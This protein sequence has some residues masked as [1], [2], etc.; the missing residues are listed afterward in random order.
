MVAAT[1][2]RIL[3]RIRTLA[4]H[5]HTGAT[6]G[7]L[8]DR[9]TQQQ[10][11]AAFEA[12]VRRHGPMVLGVCRR[13]LG[14]SHDAEDAFQATFLV[15]VRK[16]NSIR[17]VGMVGNWLYG[18]AQHTALEARR[19]AARRR[20]KEAQVTPRTQTPD[21]ACAH[22]R[23]ILDREL[24]RLPAKYRA[25]LVLCDLEGR[26]RKEAAQQL[27]LPEGT[28]AS[29][30]ARARTILAKRLTRQGVTISSGALATVLAQEAMSASPP[31]T[32]ILATVKVA[33]AYAAG[34][35]AM[36][37]SVVV[38]T[39]GVLKAMF[40]SKL[41]I[42]VIVVAVVGFLSAGWGIGPMLRTAAAGPQERAT[43]ATPAA[44]PP[45]KT[46]PNQKQ[47]VDRDEVRQAFDEMLQMLQTYQGS[48]VSANRN[49]QATR[50]VSA[51][52]FLTAFWISSE[53]AKAL[54]KGR[55]KA[56]PVNDAALDAYGLFVPA[57][58]RAGSL[59]KTLEQQQASGVKGN[60]KAI[61]ALDVFLKA[62]QKFELAIKR[63]VKT[64]AVDQA[65]QAIKDAVS[66]VEQTVQDRQTTLETLDEIERALQDLKTKVQTSKEGK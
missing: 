41:K 37:A 46:N 12:L 32:L 28:V 51:E 57:Y 3:Y 62:G 50:D 10:D 66:K 49:E 29:R 61:E 27:G 59:K 34:A 52:A 56:A 15:L 8:L 47:P 1:A 21:D 24:A 17:P 55:G 4:L 7:D 64:R 42:G 18:V 40:L 33:T 26:T 6:D 63:Q 44:D 19:S 48:K 43:T 16:A 58:E 11:E 9:Y 20:A 23:P 45:T 30:Q 54:S 38:L 65:R 5:P 14:N 39:E 22:L 53:I 25:V 31:F 35:A 13:I 60:E 36:S 2:N